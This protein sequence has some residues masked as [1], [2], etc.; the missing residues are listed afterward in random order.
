VNDSGER[1][2]RTVC[3]GAKE[4]RSCD[5]PERETGASSYSVGDKLRMSGGG[6]VRGTGG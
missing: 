3:R 4:G 5:R 6:V 2:R 1:F